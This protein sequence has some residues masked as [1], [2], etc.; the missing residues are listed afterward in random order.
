[1]TVEEHKRVLGKEE[2]VAALTSRSLRHLRTHIA[3]ID[4]RDQSR[5]IIISGY[6]S[7]R[8]RMRS[9]CSLIPHTHSGQLDIKATHPSEGRIF[10]P[11]RPYEAWAKLEFHLPLRLCLKFRRARLRES[12]AFSGCYLAACISGRWL[13]TLHNPFP[14]VV[15]LCALSSFFC[16]NQRLKSVFSFLAHLSAQRF[17]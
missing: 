4:R 2:A 11:M 8:R 7:I 9:S 13:I 14:G 1:M 10:A 15:F 12:V 6:V 16:S 3:R 5:E 17:R